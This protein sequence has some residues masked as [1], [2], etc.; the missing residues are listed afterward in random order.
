VT[1][2]HAAVSGP[3]EE[4]L[5][6][7]GSIDNLDAAIIHMLAERFKCTQQVGR[8]K[9]KHGLPPSDPQRETRQIARLRQLA[10]ESRLDPEFAETFLTFIINEVVRHHHALQASSS[11]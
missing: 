3:H 2:E 10:E 1:S 9:A 5:A 6:L 8:L 11:D 7:R 4:L